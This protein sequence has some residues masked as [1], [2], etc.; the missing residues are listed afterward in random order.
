M[1]NVQS[2]ALNIQSTAIREFGIIKYMSKLNQVKHLRKIESRI[3]K[4]LF[5]ITGIITIIA[6][7]MILME[8][9]SKGSFFPSNIGIFYLGVLVIYSIHKEL[10]RWLGK[11]TIER[12]GEI[13]VYTWI[14][15]T[16]FLYVINFIYNGEFN[17]SSNGIELTTLRD[18]SVLTLEVLGIFIFTRCLKILKHVLTK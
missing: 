13:F 3:N 18:L 10:L 11:R 12:Q 6:M 9:F 14:I 2:S 8:F 1:V 5:V 4:N 17:V 7:A 15:L 16:A